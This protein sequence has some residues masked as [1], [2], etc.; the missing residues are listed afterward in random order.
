MLWNNPEGA[1]AIPHARAAALCNDDRLVSRL[2]TR[3]AYKLT[4]R[5][6]A[7]KMTPEKTSG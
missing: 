2:Q 3:P 6:K 5:P 1:E 7:P 4:C